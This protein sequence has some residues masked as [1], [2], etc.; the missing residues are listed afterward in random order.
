[1][2]TYCRPES[3]YRFQNDHPNEAKEI[4]RALPDNIVATA[5]QTYL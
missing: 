4:L 3:F 2:S 5:H 1:M